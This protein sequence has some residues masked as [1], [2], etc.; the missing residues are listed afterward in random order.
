MLYICEKE[1]ILQKYNVPVTNV[2]GSVFVGRASCPSP[3]A[4]HILV[5]LGRVLSKINTCRKEI[6]LTDELEIN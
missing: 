5:A 6:T 3:Y 4:I 2:T 1:L